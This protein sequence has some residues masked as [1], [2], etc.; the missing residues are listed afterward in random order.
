[1][2][3]SNSELVN[4]VIVLEMHSDVFGAAHGV[5]M[6]IKEELGH[7]LTAIGATRVPGQRKCQVQR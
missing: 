3:P 6:A 4:N 7:S 2:D 5:Q 1:M